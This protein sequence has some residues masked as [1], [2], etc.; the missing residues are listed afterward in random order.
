M[1]EELGPIR[2]RRAA[3]EK[4]IDDV[5]DILKSGSEKAEKTARSV[6]D[7]VRASMQIDYFTD[8]KL[9]DMYRG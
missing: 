4:R 9:V 1:Q 7:D 3:W 5:Y 2:E 8:R 6:L